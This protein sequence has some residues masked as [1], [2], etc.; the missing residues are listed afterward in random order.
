MLVSATRAS[1][2]RSGAAHVVHGAPPGRCHP[3][4]AVVTMIVVTRAPGA[5]PART[6]R[7]PGAH[8]AGVKDPGTLSTAGP[9]PSQRASSFSFRRASPISVQ[10]AS[11][12]PR[13]P[14]E[15]HP[16]RLHHVHSGTNR[17]NA[18]TLRYVVSFGDNR[19]CCIFG[20]PWIRVLPLVELVY[21]TP[22]QAG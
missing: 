10:R 13:Q 15:P 1:R 12:I 22:V 20:F 21:G 3:G 5:H 11:S 14:R 8:P 18:E 7:A 9:D 4:H 16:P 6:R 17:I 19:G 2:R